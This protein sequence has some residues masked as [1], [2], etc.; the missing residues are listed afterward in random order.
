MRS[1]SEY[2]EKKLYPLQ[3]GVLR[4][5]EGCGTRFFLTGGTALSR[6]YFNH[7]YSDDLD[8]FVCADDTFNEEVELVLAGL[9]N[10]GFRWDDSRDFIRAGDFFTLAVEMAP[11]PDIR[12]K[13][14]FVNDVAPRFGDLAIT[15]VF[16]RTD[17]LR[18]ILSNKLTALFRFEA[19]DLADIRTI[20]RNYSFCW[21]SILDEARQK[22]AGL[23]APLAV[24]ILLG[25]PESEF[26]SVRWNKA[27]SWKDFQADLSVIASDL[28]R[29][30]ENS[31]FV[32]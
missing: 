13:L 10:E 18:N 15:Q 22:E 23:E 16:N 20:C 17:S 5:V 12:L 31:L 2:Y 29:G 11:F 27:P 26:Q 28:T 1:Y 3:D 30:I 19:K 4:C 8:F 21:G 7:R 6:G 32:A 24:E 14:D 25:M 9:A